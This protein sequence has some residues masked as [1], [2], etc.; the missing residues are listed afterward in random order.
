MS[1][2]LVVGGGAAGL[3]AAGTAALYGADVTVVERNSRPAR[4][5]MITGKGRC[6]VTNAC[7][8]QEMIANIPSNGRFLYS[9]LSAFDAEDI[10]ALLSQYGVE[11]KVERGNRVFPVSDKAVDVVDALVSFARSNNVRF[12]Y[13]RAQNL[14]VE[15]GR[16]VGVE[17]ESGKVLSAD[18]VVL[19]T[20]GCSYP[21]T[22]STG[23]G[24]R[25]AQ[26]VGH[27]IVPVRPSLVPLVTREYD[28][29]DMQGLSLKNVELRAEDTVTGKV[30]FK[31][32]G[33]MMFTHFGVTGPLVLSAS[34]HM[35]TMSPGRYRLHL[36][37]KPA[38][39]EQQLDDRLVRELSQHKNASVATMLST[40]LPRSMVS[41]A[42][43]RWRV[44]LHTQC[45]TVT[46]EQRLALVRLLKDFTVTVEDYRPIDEAIVTSGGVNVKEVNAKTMESRLVSSLYF[47]GEL[48]DVDAYTGGFNLQVAFSTGAAAG[49][50]A[51]MNEYI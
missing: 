23:D 21:R 45:N 25:M 34:A 24:Y 8:L 50:A 40:L 30:V 13:E 22:G 7:D 1:K 5:V 4:K 20:G 49:K 31:E 14:I 3:L 2:V 51:A 19:C 41:V 33:E 29:L 38:L 17:C 43:A 48:L 16:C 10:R 44:A 36:D 26:S 39:T 11:T 27:T 32:M 9:A 15:D 37:L 46:K 42:A 28:C 47:A 35:R 6:N 12:V 18:A